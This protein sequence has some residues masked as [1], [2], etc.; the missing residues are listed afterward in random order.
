LKTSVTTSVTMA[1]GEQVVGTTPI[2]PET[3]NAVPKG[4][5]VNKKPRRPV[6]EQPCRFFAT[7]KGRTAADYDL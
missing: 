4:S 2:P 6:K 7:K 5:D 1:E 3:S